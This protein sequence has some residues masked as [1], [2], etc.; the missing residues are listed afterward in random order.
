MLI[1][2]GFLLAIVLYRLIIL[3]HTLS[4]FLSLARYEMTP[5]MKDIRLTAQNMEAL[6]RKA[7]GSV[8]TI[9]NGV[10]AAGPAMQSAK[11]RVV[12][13]FQSLVGGLRQAFHRS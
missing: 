10:A 13:G 8:Q 2:V 4:E 12:T 6:S 5:T 9:E 3:L 11:R 1:P 7:V